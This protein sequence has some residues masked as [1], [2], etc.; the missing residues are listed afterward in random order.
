MVPE[1]ERVRAGGEQPFGEPR[2]DADAVRDVLAVD[3]AGV[4][5]EALAQA[6]QQRL[7]RIAAGATDDVADEEEPHD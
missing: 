7:D 5:V 2:R 6:G 1:R 4:D 3:D